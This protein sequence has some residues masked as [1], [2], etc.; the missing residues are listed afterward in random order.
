[1]A[2]SKIL[3]PCDVGVDHSFD[4]DAV[5]DMDKRVKPHYLMPSQ[6]SPLYVASLHRGVCGLEK[7]I[8]SRSSTIGIV[9]RRGV[10]LGPL[11]VAAG[12]TNCQHL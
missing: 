8:E 6:L 3:A 11:F 10:V 12:K 2:C 9:E 1:M 5:G 4:G 7:E